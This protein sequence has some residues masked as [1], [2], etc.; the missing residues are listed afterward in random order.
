MKIK[1]LITIAILLGSYNFCFSQE[2]ILTNKEVIELVKAGLSEDIIIAKINSSKAN[3]DTSSEALIELKNS[4]ISDKILLVILESSKQKEPNKPANNESVKMVDISSASGKRKVYIDSEDE[5]SEL[6]MGKELQKRGFTVVS[7]SQNADILF[8][9]E[10]ADVDKTS[11]GISPGIGGG[12][13]SNSVI[14]RPEGKLTIYLLKDNAEYLIFAKKKELGF[15]GQYLHKQA[16]DLTRQ[17]IKEL[18]KAEK[19]Q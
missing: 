18:L 15:A 7:S 11:F 12:I 8:K 3:F 2:N 14:E 13:S 6:S 10:I 9:F 1:L 17:F 5:Q 16:N 19:L 4:A